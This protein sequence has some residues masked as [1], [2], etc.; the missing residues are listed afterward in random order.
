MP[1]IA[2]DLK[3]QRRANKK[4]KQDAFD[5]REKDK[6]TKRATIEKLKAKIPKAFAMPKIDNEI[7][8][9]RKKAA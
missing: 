5:Q 4:C 1:A 7:I 8:I 2:N 9:I 6:A 3:K